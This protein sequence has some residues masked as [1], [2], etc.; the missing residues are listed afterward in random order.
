MKYKYGD[1]VYCTGNQI[2]NEPFPM[3]VLSYDKKTGKYLC[4]DTTE[5]SPGDYGTCLYLIAENM[6]DYF[7]KVDKDYS[8]EIK[9]IYNSM[10]PKNLDTRYFN[11]YDVT[12]KELLD[13][14]KAVLR[15]EEFYIPIATDDE[16]RLESFTEVMA[17]LR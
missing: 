13:Y 15:R 2:S 16:R 11:I 10:F 17:L 7:E 4:I 9:K 3:Q 8:E 12:E 5:Y 6:L 1:I 14:R